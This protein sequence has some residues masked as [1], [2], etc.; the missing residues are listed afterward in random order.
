MHTT[1]SKYGL[2]TCVLHAYTTNDTHDTSTFTH[3]CAAILQDALLKTVIRVIRWPVLLTDFWGCLEVLHD[4]DVSVRP[5]DTDAGAGA[6]G[7]VSQEKR[8]GGGGGEW[9]MASG[10][11]VV[12][13][14]G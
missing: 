10:F 2:H 11:T 14:C 4:I 5:V 1:F 6:S 9:G 12:S 8:D 13:R 7:A 3:V